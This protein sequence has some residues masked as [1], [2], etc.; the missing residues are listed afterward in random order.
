V[1]VAS[2]ALRVAVSTALLLL[3]GAYDAVVQQLPAAA[4]A[5]Q[6]PAYAIWPLGDSITFGLTGSSARIPGG[7]RAPLDAD[8]TAANVAHLF[9]GTSNQNPTQLLLNE[10]EAQHDG[11][12]GYR[13]DQVTAD[14]NGVAGGGSDA[15]GY[16]LTGAGTRAAITPDVVVIHLGTNDI[17]QR[18]DPGITYP[19]ASGQVDYS[20]ASQRAQFVKDLTLGLAGLV[21]AIYRQRPQTRIV[22]SAIAPIETSTYLAATTDF[23]QGVSRLVSYERGL[24]RAVVMADVFH[25]FFLSPTSGQFAPGLMSAGGIHPTTA[26]YA[27]MAGVFTGAIRQLLAPAARS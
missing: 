22:L 25:A 10:G 20:Q 4:A 18:Y 6:Q 27:V 19:T 2:R 26:G 12:S 5:T 7:Y 23:F 8:L 3:A 13:V 21:E 9:V 11:H 15:G 16:W 24:G 17:L 1:P 14:L